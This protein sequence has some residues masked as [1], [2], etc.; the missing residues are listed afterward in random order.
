MVI[1]G[2][3]L[4]IGI[5]DKSLHMQAV[6]LTKNNVSDSQIL[7]GLFNQISPLDEQIDSIYTDKANDI[8][9]LVRSCQIG[10]NKQ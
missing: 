8:N 3:R 6:Q 7:R 4:H 2:V 1:N 10:R 9:N 5:N